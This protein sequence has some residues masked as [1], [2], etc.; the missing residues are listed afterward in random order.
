LVEFNTLVDSY[1]QLAF[2]YRDEINWINVVARNNLAGPSG[3]PGYEGEPTRA[4]ILADNNLYDIWTTRNLNNHSWDINPESTI[5]SDP[6]IMYSDVNFVY[7]E[8]YGWDSQGY[9]H[10][11]ENSPARDFIVDTS[12]GIAYDL[13]FNPRTSLNNPPGARV[14]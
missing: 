13:E 2:W 9:F 7:V 3:G 8:H 1:T 6:T 12:S 10:L 5:P 11:A 14:Y 4:G